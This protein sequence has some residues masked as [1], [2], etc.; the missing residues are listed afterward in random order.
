MSGWGYANPN[1][2]PN[3]YLNFLSK[4]RRNITLTSLNSFGFFPNTWVVV[5]KQNRPTR[6]KLLETT[7]IFAESIENILTG[8]WPR[9]PRFRPSMPAISCGWF[10]K[11]IFSKLLKF[12]QEIAILPK[13]RIH[14]ECFLRNFKKMWHCF[15]FLEIAFQD[16]KSRNKKNNSLKL[17]ARVAYYSI[18][19]FVWF[20]YVAYL[21]WNSLNFIS[22]AKWFYSW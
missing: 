22:V 9:G 7:E 21:M 10:V 5:K 14:R 3:P 13:K 6:I 4:P 1:S 15:W 18:F 12:T 19:F 11:E 8:Y 16:C 2:N 17:L 20:L